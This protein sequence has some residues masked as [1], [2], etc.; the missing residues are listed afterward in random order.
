MKG[1]RLQ[2]FRHIGSCTGDVFAY[3]LRISKHPKQPRFKLR[4]SRLV[5]RDSAMGWQKRWTLFLYEITNQNIRKF[6]NS[7]ILMPRKALGFT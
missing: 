6:I 7:E 4:G 5:D 2:T 3:R 1:T